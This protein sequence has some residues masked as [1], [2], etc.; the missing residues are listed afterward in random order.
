MDRF[1][2]HKPAMRILL[3]AGLLVLPLISAW[4]LIVGSARAIMLGPKLGGVTETAPVVFSW[5]ALANGSLQKAIANR[6]TDAFVFRPLLIRLNNEIRSQLYG[7]DTSAYVLRG[8]KGHLIG[9]F[10]LDEYCARTEGMGAQLAAEALP[11][12]KALQEHYRSK[13]GVFV[14]LISPSKAAHLPE[15]FLDRFNCPS[16]LAARLS[17]LPDYVGALRSAGIHVV[18]AASLI[19]SRKRQYEVPL[20]PEGGEHWND[21][22]GALAVLAVVEEINRQAGRELVPPFR[23][24]YGLSSNKSKSDRELAD[25]LNVFFPPLGYV[26]ARVSIDQPVA[27]AS[28]EANQLSAALVGSSFGFLP[29]P[30]MIEKSC[31]SSL[32][33]YYYAKLGQFG[34]Q[35]FHEIKRDLTIEELGDLRDVRLMILEE[36]ESFVGRSGYGPLL[37]SL[38]A[39]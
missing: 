16:T 32:K 23:F 18:D 35:P 34:G 27:C 20:F 21:I 10:Y 6:I 19:H 30:M 38:V 25:L 4:N 9:R 31:L 5:S 24:T 2:L 29:A 12:L 22:G 11:R 37:L 28:H 13:G 1:P 15:Y 39:K 26:T 33:F 7:D 17:L 8:A 14:Y 3:A 36:N